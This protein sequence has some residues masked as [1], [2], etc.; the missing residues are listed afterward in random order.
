MI[1]KTCSLNKIR[2]FLM[3]KS[4]RFFLKKENVSGEYDTFLGV[5][6]S[7]YLRLYLD[8]RIKGTR[9]TKPEILNDN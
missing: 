7:T 1:T 8:Q 2:V 4:S 6:A 5:E 9:Y 3:I